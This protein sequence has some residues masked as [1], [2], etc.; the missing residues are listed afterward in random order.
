MKVLIVDD[1]PVGRAIVEAIVRKRGYEPVVV[2]GGRAA[3]A[4]IAREEI[5]LVITDWNM[6]EIDGIELCR[7]LR[8]ANRKVY[9]YVLILTAQSGKERFLEALDAGADDFMTKPVDPDELAARLKSGERIVALQK[10][11]RQMEGLLSICMRCKKIRE[12]KAWVPVDEYVAGHTAT[13]F[14]HAFCPECMKQQIGE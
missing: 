14:S 4:A 1:D 2:D 7:R 5:P 3:L 13:S 12:G 10:E 8:T 9:T 6:P 11:M